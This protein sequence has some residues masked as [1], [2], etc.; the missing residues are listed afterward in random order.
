MQGGWNARSIN[1]AFSEVKGPGPPAP[2]PKPGFTTSSRPSEESS[3]P[4]L[5]LKPRIIAG[6]FPKFF[7]SLIFV[8]ILFWV[9]NPIVIIGVILGID[10]IIT[11][12][13]SA[14]VVVFI[15]VFLAYMNLRARL[16]RFFSDRAEFYEGFLNINQRVVRYDRITD[17]THNRSVWE[18]IWG[19]GSVHLNTA[20]SNMKEVKISYIRDS[21]NVYRKVQKLVKSHSAGRTGTEAYR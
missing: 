6:I 15:S 11:Y 9:M 21:E 2:S 17:I 13:L 8:A 12:L 18:R 14:S 1:E 3:N 20:G 19:T 5:V 10:P 7:G 4:D 16:Y